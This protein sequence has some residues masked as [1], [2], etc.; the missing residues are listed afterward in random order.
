M[1]DNYEWVAQPNSV[2]PE[3]SSLGKPVPSS[4]FGRAGAGIEAEA[5][6]VVIEGLRRELAEARNLLFNARAYVDV[7]ADSHDKEPSG[8]HAKNFCASIDAHLSLSR[9][10]PEATK[11][12][13]DNG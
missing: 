8:E 5:A 10:S 7:F 4:H 11:E 12:E 13:R 3:A 9:P 6:R 1:S 2:K